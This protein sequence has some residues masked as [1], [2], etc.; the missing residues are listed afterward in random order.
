MCNG[1]DYTEPVIDVIGLRYRLAAAGERECV[2]V[3]SGKYVTVSHVFP[4]MR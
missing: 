3:L 4:A 1:I 2:F